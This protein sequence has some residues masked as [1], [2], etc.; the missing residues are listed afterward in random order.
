MADYICNVAPVV[1]TKDPEGKETQEPRKMEYTPL[2]RAIDE[3]GKEV[4]VK[5]QTVTIN[6][7]TINQNISN[8][9]LELA[10]WKALKAEIEKG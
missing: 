8:L 2:V 9:E 3:S 1:I 5:G 7:Q 4:K 6:E 10:R